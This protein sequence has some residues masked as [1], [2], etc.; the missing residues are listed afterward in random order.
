[1]NTRK[2]LCF[3]LPA[4]VLVSSKLFGHSLSENAQYYTNASYLQNVNDHLAGPLCPLVFDI[5]FFDGEDRPWDSIQ[6]VTP[7]CPL[8]STISGGQSVGLPIPTG[9]NGMPVPIW[10]EV[11]DPATAVV[12]LMKVY[13]TP[14]GCIGTIHIEQ[15][16][17]TH[18]WDY[19][20][21]SQNVSFTPLVGQNPST[22]LTLDFGNYISTGHLI[23]NIATGYTLKVYYCIPGGVS[24][25]GGRKV[26]TNSPSQT[27]RQSSPTNA[28]TL[29]SAPFLAKRDNDKE[30]VIFN[31][32]INNPV[33]DILRI[34]LTQ[35]HQINQPIEASLWSMQG[36]RLPE[37]YIMAPHDENQLDILISHL[38]PGLYVLRLTTE[39]QTSTHI[40]VKI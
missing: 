21:V 28:S 12:L 26:A 27:I 39:T 3:L 2:A 10:L 13:T 18:L 20:A 31:A 11:F 19:N 30:A 4:L 37:R 33:R 17:T 1:M 29:F 34:R 9:E 8:R 35:L 14:G 32:V 15:L 23:A 5:V 7:E 16:S 22:A 40:F 38:S 36:Q 25:G 6:T 24:P